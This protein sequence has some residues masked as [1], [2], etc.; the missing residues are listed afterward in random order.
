MGSAT[1]PV[2]PVGVSPIDQD[3]PDRHQHREG[4]LRRDAEDSGRHGHSAGIAVATDED[5]MAHVWAEHGVTNPWRVMQR[6]GDRPA[7]RYIPDAR[8]AV[9]RGGDEACVVLAQDRTVH[10]SDMPKR[11]TN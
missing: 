6:F 8:R 5:H 3:A 10:S 9:I 11:M 2:A 1:V 4:S 7:R